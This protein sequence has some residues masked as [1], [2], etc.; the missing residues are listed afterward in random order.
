MSL[1]S[2]RGVVPK[3]SNGLTHRPTPGPTHPETV[4]GIVAVS[5][6]GGF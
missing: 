1:T 2:I 5:C 3:D 4:A 6:P